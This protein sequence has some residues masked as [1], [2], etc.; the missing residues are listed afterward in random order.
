MKLPQ[1]FY[2][3]SFFRLTNAIITFLFNLFIFSYIYRIDQ[4]ASLEDFA[5]ALILFQYTF[6]LSEWG[7]NLYSL[8]KIKKFDYFKT[9]KFF[10]DTVIISKI[11]VGLFCVIFLSILFLSELFIFKNNYFFFSLIVLTFCA[12]LNPLWFYQSGEKIQYLNLP[13]F[14]YKLIQTIFL[15]YTLNS[16]NFYLFFISQSIVYLL[17][18][19]DFLFF[20]K[21]NI[22]YFFKFNIKKIVYSIVY[23]KKMFSF[24]LSNLYNHINISFWGI[25]L[26]ILNI[27]S[28]IVLFNIVD[29]IWRTLNVFLQSTL[30]PIFRNFN[31][32]FLLSFWNYLFLLFF[33][34]LIYFLIDPIINFLF[35]FFYDDLILIFKI[36]YF[37]VIMFSVNK[38]ISYLIIG[39]N[40]ISLMNKMNTLFLVIHFCFF[41][42]WFIF[43]NHSTLEII[44]YLLFLNLFI[45]VFLFF[46][47]KKRFFDKK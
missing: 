38:L 26:I 10:I 18:F 22:N 36:L 30:E 11:I 29:V 44:L 19:L 34:L 37:V 27:G 28:E 20:S 32:T 13:L 5:L 12:S 40:Q 24:F 42:V 25:G 31:K 6:I 15:F 14:V 47:L 4:G 9:R 41:I 3:Q 39:R 45:L 46:I 1:F 35:P 23:L 21:K 33:L 2:T 17:L 7:F 16:N 43:S 8:D